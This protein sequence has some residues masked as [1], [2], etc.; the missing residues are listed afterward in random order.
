MTYQTCKNSCKID[1]DTMTCSG[2]CK[3][4]VKSY[5]FVYPSTCIKNVTNPSSD[6]HCGC[7]TCKATYD[8]SGHVT[9]S[10][11]SCGAT[12]KTC[13]KEIIDVGNYN[14]EGCMCK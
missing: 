7:F 10:G 2:Q 12:E 5:I 14:A 3:A 4:E 1:S 13:Q 11:E 8:D 6:S 9:C